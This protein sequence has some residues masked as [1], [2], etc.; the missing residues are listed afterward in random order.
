[1]GKHYSALCGKL[2]SEVAMD[3]SFDTQQ[4]KFD[5]LSTVHLGMILVNKCMN[6]WMDPVETFIQYFSSQSDPLQK[7]FHLITLGD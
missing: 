6:E 3:L 4:N 1:M 2:V 7:V 5:I